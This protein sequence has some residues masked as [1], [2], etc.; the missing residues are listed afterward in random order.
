LLQEFWEWLKGPGSPLANL[1]QIV[2]A[3][4][5]AGGVAYGLFRRRLR[6]SGAVIARLQD[7]LAHRTQQLDRARQREKQLEADCS[8]LTERLIETTVTKLQ[9]EIRDGNSIAA[10]HIVQDWLEREGEAISTLLRFEAQWATEHATGDAHSAGLIVA[11]AFARAAHAKWPEDEDAAELAEELKRFYNNAHLGT[12]PSFRMALTMLASA[13]P[14][15][16]LGAQ[17]VD[18][19]LELEQVALS[20][21]T[22]G[23]FRLALLQIERVVQVF[24]SEL[25]A[26]AHPALRARMRR[27][28]LLSRVGR[29]HDG[30][31]DIE[32]IVATF[33]RAH[34]PEHPH[35]LT[36]RYLLAQ[37]LDNLG[38]SAEALPDQCTPVTSF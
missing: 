14:D 21:Q 33:T 32:N 16:L 4:I 34:G 31:D 11:E 20:L 36:S 18:R 24:R 26:A 30:L 6:H 15:R 22:R 19:A 38:R 17:S 2:G 5:F 28:R 9:R 23:Y 7:D 3:V 29:A 13:Q 8:D 35:T 10:H 1:L 37:L 27:V 12:A 25:G